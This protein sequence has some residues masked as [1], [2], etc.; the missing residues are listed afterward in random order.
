MGA[1]IVKP[2]VPMAK[3]NVTPI[4]D[5]ALTLVVILMMTMPMLSV[6]NIDVEVP[7]ARTRG[8]ESQSRLTVTLGRSGELAID[9]DMVEFAR[10][11]NELHSRLQG[12]G[13]GTLVVVRADRGVQ[14]AQVADI[15]ARVRGAGAQRMA[16]AASPKTEERQ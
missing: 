9:D 16:V 11:D 6:A 14:Y 4:I 10:F 15:L 8:I 12:T 7:Q 3:I 2:K 13:E 1:L 5:V